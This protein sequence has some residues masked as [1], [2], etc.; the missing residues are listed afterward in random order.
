MTW[1][2]ISGVDGNGVNGTS[3]I[4]VGAFHLSGLMGWWWGH[5]APPFTSRSV[6][7]ISTLQP[8]AT[9]SFKGMTVPYLVTAVRTVQL[10]MCAVASSVD[11]TSCRLRWQYL[12]PCIRSHD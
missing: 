6:S 4:H 2:L 9:V 12:R 3:L 1:C 11:F 10:C 7:G 8:S 5:L